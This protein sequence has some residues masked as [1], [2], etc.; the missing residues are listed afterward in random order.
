MPPP[1]ITVRRPSQTCQ[2][3]E[4]HCLQGDSYPKCTDLPSCQPTTTNPTS[5]NDQAESSALTC[6]C[7]YYSE[8]AEE[9]RQTNVGRGRK[10]GRCPN[11]DFNSFTSK[12]T[13]CVLHILRNLLQIGRCK[14]CRSKAKYLPGQGSLDA[15]SSRLL[16]FRNLK[17]LYF[18]SLNQPQGKKKLHFIQSRHL[19]KSFTEAQSCL[20]QV[21]ARKNGSFG[22]T[23]F[24][25]GEVRPRKQ[26]H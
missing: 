9:H 15:V 5:T 11:V 10:V 7:G 19:I 1:L 25:G 2:E 17:L 16:L 3:L 4:Q 6:F 18:S 26:T 20:N 21:Q 8:K 23:G 24:S 13:Q 22:C 14:F 12:D